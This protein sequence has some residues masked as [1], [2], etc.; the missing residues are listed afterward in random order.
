MRKINIAKVI[1]SKRKEKGITQDDL[2]NFIGVS[3]ASVSKW[4]T[5]QSYPDIVHLPLL[6]AYFNVSLDDLM[7]YE[8]QMASE[9]I[10]KLYKELSTEFAAKPFDEVMNR[11]RDISKKYHS[12]FPLILHIGL[13][14]LN[15]G[16]TSKNE[17]QRISTVAEA[18]GLFIRVKEQSKETDLRKFAL[19]LEA[20]CEMMLGNPDETIGLLKDIVPSPPSDILLSQAYHVTGKAKEAKIELQRSICDNILRIFDCMPTYL[21]LCADDGPRFEET[22]RRCM[23]FIKIFNLKKLV[24][25]AIMPFY[26]AAAQCYVTNENFEAS[27]GMLETYTD[28]V[29]SDIYPLKLVKGDDFFDLV[30]GLAKKLPFGTPE[31]PRDEKSIKQSMA[32]AV[33]ENPAFSI[34]SD[35]PR[36]KKLVEK[37]NKNR[38]E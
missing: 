2:A 31:L 32:D 36:F 14:Y 20:T 34:F 15:Y 22:C 29:T 28:I 11:C 25:T 35:E 8:P 37:L 6:A 17:A 9:D 30:D 33:I 3:K 21:V 12:C 27:L 5:E 38:I 19:H 13:L 1:A 16:W 24:P 18:K 4:E 7:G 10:R 26:L 23:E